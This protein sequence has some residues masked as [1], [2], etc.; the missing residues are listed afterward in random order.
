MVDALAPFHRRRFILLALVVVVA[1]AGLAIVAGPA[2]AYSSYKHSDANSCG[3]CHPGGDTNVVPTD[4]NCTA[5]HTGG[6][7]A[8]STSQ[9]RTCW[10]CHEP[11]QDMSGVQTGAGCAAGCHSATPHLGS[12]VQA[13]TTCHGVTQSATNPGTSAHHNVTTVYS[14]PTCSDCHASPHAAYVVGVACATC[15]VGVEPTHPAAVA[16]PVPT[17]AFTA[18]PAIVNY[19]A[20]TVL[21]GS[22]KSGASPL[23]GKTIT[24]QVKPAGSAAFADV[25]TAVT[26]ADGTFAFAAVSPTVATTYRVLAPGAVVTSTTVRPSLK[27]LDLQVVPVLTLAL[28]KTSIKLGATV[29]AKG[30]ITPLRPGA[31]V[32]VVIQKKG[33]TWKTI[34]TVNRAL[35]ASGAAYTYTY[36]PLKKGTYRVQAS[37]AATADLAA[38]KTALKTFK[39][40]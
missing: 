4:A 28:S 5:C 16:M 11:G 29:T 19:G 15:H 38:F 6:F 9:A 35:D 33:T 8:R 2:G 20:S 36:K 10:S 30:A 3:S 25:T 21:G 22:L 1:L 14:A 27:T 32:K 7:V 24:L 23:A 39:V 40:K 37:V 31:T 26:A 17:L 34:K 18:T 12:N 13:C